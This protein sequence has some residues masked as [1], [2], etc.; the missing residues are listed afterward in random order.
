MS[1]GGNWTCS[2]NIVFRIE[3]DRDMVCRPAEEVVSDHCEVDLRR[4]LNVYATGRNTIVSN[5]PELWL[6]KSANDDLCA[7]LP[8]FGIGAELMDTRCRLWNVCGQ[9]ER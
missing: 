5:E 9:V 2:Q 4:R 8:S 1:G 6:A 3:P 7:H